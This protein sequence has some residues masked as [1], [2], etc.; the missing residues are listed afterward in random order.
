MG[1]RSIAAHEM[2]KSVESSLP[3]PIFGTKPFASSVETLLEE[4]TPLPLPQVCHKC[5]KMSPTWTDSHVSSPTVVNERAG[6]LQ[7]S[8]EVGDFWTAAV[9]KVFHELPFHS[10][11]LFLEEFHYAVVSSD[12]LGDSSRW[13]FSDTVNNP[14]QQNESWGSPLQLHINSPNKFS[15][16]KYGR[17]KSTSINRFCLKSRFQYMTTFFYV[18]KTL[19]HLKR[20]RGPR[21]RILA[22]LLIVL[23]LMFRQEYLKARY[24]KHKA[25]A[26]LKSILC[27]LKRLGLLQ[28]NYFAASKEAW[29]QSS[30]RI[31]AVMTDL[32][33]S[34]LDLLYY[35]MENVT[36][37][38]LPVC[39][40]AELSK[41]CGIYDVA[42]PDLFYRL[43]EPAADV[44][45]RMARV[46]V[47]RKFMLCCLLSQNHERLVCDLPMCNLLR[48][49]FSNCISNQNPH[50]NE[51]DRLKLVTSNLQE[52]QNL[53]LS[54][55]TSMLKHTE[56]L[57]LRGG[58]TG[59]EQPTK[60]YSKLYLPRNDKV[61]RTQSSVPGTNPHK[62]STTLHS[63]RDLER[64]LIVSNED[65]A[66]NELSTKLI[67]RKLRELLGIWQDGCDVEIYK[68][69]QRSSVN[70]YGNR[71]L[72]LDV[73]KNPIDVN[74]ACGRP[75][76]P[77]KLDD[78]IDITNVEDEPSDMELDSD[79]EDFR[80]A[81]V[82]ARYEGSESGD[83]NVNH[84]D[85]YT[86]YD[87]TMRKHRSSERTFID[88]Q[89][90]RFRGLSDKELKDKLAEGILKFAEENRQGRQKLRTQKSFELL[91][92]RK[93]SHWTTLGT[94]R[95]ISSASELTLKNSIL[96]HKI[97][98]EE[99]IPI[100][101]E[102]QEIMDK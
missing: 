2:S 17:M 98:S 29:S 73:V 78:E 57:N 23:R 45:S 55:T 18:R 92:Q 72:S 16:T 53:T 12:L 38:L 32:L 20:V 30:T 74:L 66:A 49:I 82:A 68:K 35:S 1:T 48:K 89:T 3:E 58:S 41:Y 44:D 84:N 77:P 33:N 28:S 71:G 54:L 4:T 64:L 63:L 60:R 47:M 5:G 42:L 88:Y 40:T 81:P 34:S 79:Y 99:T 21:R 87:E 11:S 69:Q 25:L 61:I 86:D 37:E 62:L 90:E 101:Y 100:F 24:T 56:L 15:S 65:T 27:S 22:T 91:R 26:T 83:D 9:Q 52:L 95:Q 46:K 75:R 67:R 102:L 14:D 80:T 70:K 51:L 6:T 94:L 76:K 96:N 59:Q 93:S 39:D 36:K 8:A 7:Q 43:T 10:N 85:D 97:S 19:G 13:K 50:I 31:R